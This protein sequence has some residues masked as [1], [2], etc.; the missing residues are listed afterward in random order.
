MRNRD[1]DT[2]T[3]GILHTAALRGRTSIV[4][5]LLESGFKRDTP[6]LNG[7][8]Q[9]G[10]I[11]VAK[12]LLDTP[13]TGLDRL[14]MVNGN[15]PFD[16]KNEKSGFKAPLY[17]AAKNGHASMVKLLL[18]YGAVVEYDHVKKAIMENEQILRV[19]VEGEVKLGSVTKEHY[20][21]T[22]LSLAQK[23]NKKNSVR[24][25]LEYGFRHPDPA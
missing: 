18:E 1:G 19:L 22:L 12:L 10:H 3:P 2:M 16:E 25:L 17:W 21:S 9:N 11:E 5:L 6:A 20:H 13:G 7:A 14:A 24:V 8:A 23:E 15:P 4:R